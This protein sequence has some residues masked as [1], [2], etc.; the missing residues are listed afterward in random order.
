MERL[1]ELHDAEEVVGFWLSA[2]PEKWFVKNDS[3]DEEIRRRGGELHARAV[4]GEL[5]EWESSAIGLL[6]LILLLDQFSRNLYREDARAWEQDAQ[7]LSLSRRMIARNED[8]EMDVVRR[9]WI[10]MPFMH[11]E[12]VM[13]QREGMVYFRE[14]LE[15][16]DT[17]K[18]AQLHL[19]I[20]ERFGRFPHRNEVLGREMTPAETAYLNEGGFRG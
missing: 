13:A 3:F 17:L 1:N 20:I 18:Y 11:T 5:R 6:G 12:D 14:R 15:D 19:D 16:A 4:G 7:A 10:Y 8:M 9:R 2:G